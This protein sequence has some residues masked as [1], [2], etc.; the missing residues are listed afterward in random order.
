MTSIGLKKCIPPYAI[1]NKKLC[2][3]ETVAVDGATW[4]EEERERKRREEKRKKRS[5]KGEKNNNKQ[6]NKHT[7]DATVCPL[8]LCLIAIQCCILFA[9]A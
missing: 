7:F 4:R 9:K 5:E 6:T 1:L 2:V 3:T 8:F